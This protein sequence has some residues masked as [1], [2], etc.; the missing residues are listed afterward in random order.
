ME[1]GPYGR[2]TVEQVEP[3]VLDELRSV[4]A[5]GSVRYV[6][7]EGSCSCAFRHVLA[8][9]P[10]DWFEG[11]FADEN[12][13]DRARATALVTELLTLVREHVPAG[14]ELYPTWDGEHSRQP[15]GAL[16][17]DLGA[18]CPER[19]FFLEGFLHRLRQGPRNDGS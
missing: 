11:M 8:E 3:E 14:V 2:L 4:F 7:V 16:E 19:F 6:G 15:K 5:K 18:I 13:D 10:F 17:M 9:E 12:E 1:P